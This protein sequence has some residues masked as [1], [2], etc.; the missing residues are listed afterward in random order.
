MRLTEHRVPLT[1]V[2][3]LEPIRKLRV[4]SVAGPMAR[5]VGD[6][7]LALRLI[8]GRHRH[9]CASRPVAGSHPNRDT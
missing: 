7:R 3:F 1:G 8:A 4:M 6:L 5:S 9:R 2:F